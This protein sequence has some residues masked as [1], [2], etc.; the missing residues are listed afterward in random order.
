MRRFY[1]LPGTPAGRYRASSCLRLLDRVAPPGRSRIDWNR[2]G[3][4]K[5]LGGSTVTSTSPDRVAIPDGLRHDR[6]YRRYPTHRL[7]H[8]DRPTT[9]ITDQVARCDEREHGFFRA[10]RGDFG[11]GPQRE[12]LRFVD[13][14]PLSGAMKAVEH[15]LVDAVDGPVAAT[16]APLPDDPE[17]M[18][19]HIKQVALFMRADD[20]GVCELPPYAVYSVDKNGTPV[21]LGHTHAIAVLVDQSYASFAAASGRDWL[22]NSQ[23]FRSYSATALIS[24]MLA[25]Y[26]RRLGYSA[27][28]HH[29]MDY[30]VV[31]PPI[32]MMAGLGEICRIGVIVLH[33]FMGPRFKAAVVTTDLPLQPDRPIDFGLQDF[34][35]SCK[36][37]ARECPSNSITD[38]P[39]T[40][41]NGYEIWRNDIESC[42]RFRVTNARGASCGRCIKVCP[43][44]KA[45][46]WY[47]AVATRLAAR[48]GLA[49]RGL[50]RLDD[51]LGYGKEDRDL[52][53][54][55][56]MED[57]NG[58]IAPR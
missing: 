13:K 4:K 18:S 26:I 31:V 5:R 54:W 37:C 55:F 2:G 17:I 3:V 11:P 43:W 23:S 46:T 38:G 39:K 57:V 45:D 10:L 15:H 9:K 24:C 30:K 29:S 40:M 8:V 49:R 52:Q 20:T 58:S 25:D 21:E 22:S 32:L 50:I 19:R 35:N 7:R 44:N 6:L 42:A 41:H 16:R 48:S 14:Y 1:R 53:W 56:D 27:R 28:A 51:L 36:K 33:P 47:H 34:C 12:F